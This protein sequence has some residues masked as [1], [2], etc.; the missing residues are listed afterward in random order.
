MIIIAAAGVMVVSPR[1]VACIDFRTSANIIHAAPKY[2]SVSA[3]RSFYSSNLFRV[4][5]YVYGR[6]TLVRPKCDP[7]IIGIYLR[8]GALKKVTKI[9]YHRI[10]SVIFFSKST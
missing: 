8:G 1:G 2:G 3:A 7:I 10:A 9:K 5:K 6:A 4:F